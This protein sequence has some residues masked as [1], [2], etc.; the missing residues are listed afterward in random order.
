VKRWWLQAA[1]TRKSAPADTRPF[2]VRLLCS[3]RPVLKFSKRGLNYIG[4]KGSADF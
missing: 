2:F 3:I 1:F 4:I